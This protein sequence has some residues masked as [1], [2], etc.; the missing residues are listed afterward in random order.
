[1]EQSCNPL[2]ESMNDRCCS[3]KSN[4]CYGVSS[5]KFVVESVPLPSAA[6]SAFAYFFCWANVSAIVITAQFLTNFRMS[7]FDAKK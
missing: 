1:M 5:R 7:S 4:K 3:A 6:A 2:S